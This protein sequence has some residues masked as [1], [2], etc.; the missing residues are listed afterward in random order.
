[1]NLELKWIKYEFH[2]FLELFLYWKSLSNINYLV[3]TTHWTARQILKGVGANPQE[4]HRLSKP[5]VGR[6]VNTLKF[7]GFI[8]KSFRPKGYGLISA[9][10]SEMSADD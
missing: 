5:R 6:R 8:R 9:A 2:K 4:L 7:Q 3:F 1:M 10:W